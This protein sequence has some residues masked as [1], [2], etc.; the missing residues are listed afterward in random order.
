M[1]CLTVSANKK[2][3]KL[4]HLTLLKPKK[5]RKQRIGCLNSQTIIFPRI[6]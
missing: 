6:D 5:I 2:E 4:F 3:K 1:I